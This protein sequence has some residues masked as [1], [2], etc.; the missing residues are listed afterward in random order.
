MSTITD[1]LQ[2]SWVNVYICRPEF[3]TGASS[4]SPYYL[5]HLQT[6]MAINGFS[7]WL[8][9]SF[10][11]SLCRF[12]CIFFVSSSSH[13]SVQPL[14]LPTEPST[15]SSTCQPPRSHSSSHSLP[16]PLLSSI[17]PTSPELWG[18]QDRQVAVVTGRAEFFIFLF[19]IFFSRREEEE[20]ERLESIWAPT[21]VSDRDRQKGRGLVSGWC[22]VSAVVCIHICLWT[23]HR[24]NCKICYVPKCLGA[25]PCIPYLL[26]TKHA[27][28][29]VATPHTHTHITIW[30]LNPFSN[31][32]IN[33]NVLENLVGCSHSC[34]GA[35]RV[36]IAAQVTWTHVLMCL[37]LVLIDLGIWIPLALADLSGEMLLLLELQTQTDGSC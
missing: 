20:R 2:D 6:L 4:S 26:L 13:L 18:I 22:L 7:A 9:S 11:S 29:I 8:S 5:F 37:T 34:A 27:C 10:S 21:D 24:M 28:V 31:F 35:C 19:C 14:L 16:L 32:P 17:S 1:T 3:H 33:N 36:C 30:V 25:P 15:F 12:L 23:W